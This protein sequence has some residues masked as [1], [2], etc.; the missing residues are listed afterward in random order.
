M[1]INRISPQPNFRAVNKKYFEWA[2]K[3]Y[4]LVKNVSTEW[5]QRLSYDVFL[6]KEIS[7]RDGLDT[8][9]A[10]KKYI[11]KTDECIEDLIN[12]LRSNL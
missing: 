10:A 3:D 8:V 2:K 11:N 9:I 12:R 1:Q 7:V 6:F 4:S 5:L